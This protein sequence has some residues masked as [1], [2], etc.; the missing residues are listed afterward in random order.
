MGKYITKRVL[1]G[2]VTL[3]ITITITFLILRTLPADPAMMMLGDMFTEEQ[4]Q[5]LLQDFGLDKPLWQQYIIY[6][7]NLI[8][9]D[10]G[11]SFFQR[12]PV[13]D[14]IKEKLPWTLLLMVTTQIITM[15][16]GIPLGITSGY[17]R[18]TAFD[19]V[20]NAVA[21]FGISIFVPWLGFTLL[22]FFGFRLPIFPVGGAYTVGVAE[23]WPKI[24]DVARHL[25]L[26]VI[27]LMVIFLANYVLYTRGSIIDV[28]EEDYVK[29]ARSKGMKE[30]RV[31]W[32]HAAKNAMI[33]TVTMAGMM[34]G[35]M[36]GGA[37][38]TETIYAY[39]GVGRM[40]YQAV[41]QQ[42][43]PVLQGAFI[44]LA[45]SVI[46]MNIV[47][48]IAIVYLDPRIKLE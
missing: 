17:K 47:A 26:P 11:M 44:V 25:V 46:A 3:L 24:L 19:Q 48:D 16:I 32:K 21:I 18:G 2:L 14:I 5:A 41:G 33:P 45:L 35:R 37:V 39:P 31:L 30:S 40:I 15:L 10:L 28:M 8:R 7:G 22:Y 1:K 38:L 27:T 34:L 43:Y 9:G 12:R 6:L 4:R 29:T 42:D 36:V 13:M 23:G 20:V